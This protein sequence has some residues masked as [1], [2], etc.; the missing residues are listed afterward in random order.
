MSIQPNASDSFARATTKGVDVQR[1]L[2]SDIE[3]YVLEAPVLIRYAPTITGGG[4]HPGKFGAALDG[5]VSLLIKPLCQQHP[6][7]LAEVAA[8]KVASMLGWNDLMPITVL[9][10]MLC[11]IHD[12]VELVAAQVHIPMNDDHP[13][14]SHFDDD[15]IWRAAIFDRIIWQTDR[16][17]S[18]YLGLPRGEAVQKLILVDNGLAFGVNQSPMNSIFTSARL[19]ADIPMKFAR[20]IEEFMRQPPQDLTNLIHPTRTQECRNRAQLLLD[21]GKIL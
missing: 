8:W 3:R 20:D 1:H 9:R 6:S 10:P 17:G 14:I 11:P 12:Q 15:D 7:G 18:N 5:G 2:V 13:D 16:G 4:G 19:G 21:E